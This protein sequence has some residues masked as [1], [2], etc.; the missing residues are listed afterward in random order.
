MARDL[1][2]PLTVMLFA[3]DATP[4]SI[5][6]LGEQFALGVAQQ[7]FDVPRLHLPTAGL[8]PARDR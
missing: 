1:L 7:F 5:E 3:D 6:R 4:Q 8:R 2:L